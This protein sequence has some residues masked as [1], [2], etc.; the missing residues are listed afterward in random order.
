MRILTS[1][2][3]PQSHS[4]KLFIIN[5]SPPFFLT[6]EVLHSDVTCFLGLLLPHHW[7]AN[8]NASCSSISEEKSRTKIRN[9]TDAQEI[10]ETINLKVMATSMCNFRVFSMKYL[11]KSGY[12]NIKF[13]PIKR[14]FVNTCWKNYSHNASFNMS[15]PT[16][17]MNFWCLQRK[18]GEMV[19]L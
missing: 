15:A 6:C 4:L 10:Y 18:N 8:K 19:K 11:E 7:L 2:T 17:H 3:T 9:L 13:W 12:H 16:K 14:D 5:W 1:Q